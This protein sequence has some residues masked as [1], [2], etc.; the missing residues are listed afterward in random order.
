MRSNR[1]Q[2]LLG[3]FFILSFPSHGYFPC[4]KYLVNSKFSRLKFK[5]LYYQNQVLLAQIRVFSIRRATSVAGES[6]TNQMT[7]IIAVTTFIVVCLLNVPN[8]LTFEVI[9]LFILEY[10]ELK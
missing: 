8:M 7:C 5:N 1:L 10:Q 6:V 9:T 4:N 2:H 3:I